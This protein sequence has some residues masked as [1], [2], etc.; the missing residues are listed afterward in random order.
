MTKVVDQKSDNDLIFRCNCGSNHFVTFTWDSEEPEWGLEVSIVDFP[1][2]IWTRIKNALRYI[3]S[4][5][6][7]YWSDVE[8]T[9]TDLIKLRR[10]INKYLITLNEISK[11][12]TIKKR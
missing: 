4:G 7:L 3:I 6:K 11:N 12:K 2:E 5:G 9:D 1:A 10:H 8:L